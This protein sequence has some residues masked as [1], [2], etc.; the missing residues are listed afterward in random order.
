MRFALD[1][2]RWVSPEQWSRMT[3]RQR[4]LLRMPDA[5][6]QPR[7]RTT[8]EATGNVGVMS[9]SKDALYRQS[10]EA[11]YDEAGSPPAGP[12]RQGR[13]ND[14]ARRS[15]GPRPTPE[16]PVTAPFPPIR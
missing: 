8:T 9:R 11:D 13:V 15:P 6:D 7:P 12:I 2:A 10:G 5:V 16:A 1:P 14:G 4:E 3:T